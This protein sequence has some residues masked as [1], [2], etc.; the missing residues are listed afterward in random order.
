MLSI[1]FTAI[2]TACVVGAAVWARGADTPG[3]L[4]KSHPR[5]LG[6]RQ[7]LQRLAKQRP[8]AYRR[9]VNVA[10]KHKADD[11][12]KL[13][14][15][16]LVCAIEGDKDLGR[17]A[18]AKVM[19]AISGP[20]PK[21]HRPF[22]STL[23]RCAIVYDLC[24]ESW[25]PPQRTAFHT[26]M[27]RVVDANVRSETHVFHNGWYG[28]KNWGIGLA[29]YATYYENPR[30]ATIL[31][32]VKTDFRTRAAPALELA[33]DGGGWGEGYYIH[34]WLYEW[35]FFCEVA[36]LCD[37]TDYYAMAPG[38]FR[39]RA[40]A[41]MFEMYPGTGIYG[42]RRP[43]PM[44]DGGG[45]VFGGDRDKALSARRILAGRYRDDAAH[46]VV[47]AFNET[48][49]RS[50]VGVY[51]Y[52]DLLWRDAT[53]NRGDLASF[54]LSHFSGGPGYI[55]ARSSWDDT[56][57]H[58]FFKCGDRF[59]AH[60]HL[61]VGNFL[62]YR[63]G[64]LVG[65][66]GHYDGFGTPHDVN[67]HLRT[68]A[69]NT[70]RV[71]DPAETW[72]GIR[73]G[74]VTGNDGGQ[75]HNWAHHN[76]AVTD[77][78]AWKKG[79]KLYDIADMLAFEDRGKWLYAAGDCSRAYSPKKLDYFTRQ[80][81][82]I[83]PGTFVI[84]DR[85]AVRNARFKK[86]WTLQTAK[87]PEGKSGKWTVT[88]GKG[89]LF[90][91]TLLPAKTMVKLISG[92]ELYSYGGKTYPPKRNTG[93]A[94]ECRM[95]VS[96]AKSAKVDHFL[97]VLTATDASTDAAPEA[98]VT[99]ADT[100][101][102][103]TVGKTA[104]AFTKPAVGGSITFNGARRTFPTKITPAAKAPMEIP[105][106]V[107]KYFP[108]KGD[109]IDVGVTGDW[110]ASLKDTRAK[111]DKL[112]ARVSKALQDG[113][114]Y[115][116][117]KNPR[118][119]PS[120]VYRIVKTIE[121]LEPLPTVARR[122]RKV[123]NTDYIAIMKKIGIRKW[124]EDKGVKQ[125]WIWGYHG[126]VV[127]LWESNMAGPFGDISNSNRDP[128]DLPVLRNTYTVYH[129]NYQRGASEAVE[130]HMHQFEAVLNHVD[131]RRRT[132]PDKWDTLLFWGK[133]VGSDR[134]GKIVRPGC[135]W[136]HY[137]PNAEG[138]YD[139]ANKRFVETDIED[140]RPDGKGTRKRMN[141]DRWEGNSLKWFVYWMQNLPGADSGLTY[142]GKKLTNW[143]VFIGDF[144]AAMGRG[145]KLVEK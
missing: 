31:A 63:N 78:A 39:N 16:A 57:T 42:S 117:Y 23:A 75:H 104:I 19:K 120:L 129:Y 122:G 6:S 137:P 58:F 94:P 109:L 93:P 87:R 73:A 115:H 108:V 24:Y 121:Y 46:H 124:V 131:G 61:D 64:E 139:W 62:I 27:N 66:G 72:P 95:E 22:G 135:G 112:A 125:V 12:A 26:F 50:S 40:V 81:V 107:V 44:G 34:Y 110:G 53:I 90:I 128:K 54:K 136:S 55:Y 35:L 43:I 103:V 88:N 52:K 82:Y 123:P 97:H 18:V 99:T 28:Y 38:F 113:S 86:T 106:L 141:C 36:R 1:R 127:N 130:D 111:T 79:R 102:Q 89:R 100:Q 49:P 84:F 80:I 29:C 41:G 67:Y 45:R 10:R 119:K 11:H 142:R 5:L 126:G 3:P 48:T 8:G 7:H 15:M 116:G 132:P 51:A 133:F 14:S 101:V 114:R 17:Q 74:R 37:G 4:P 59:T 20:I 143:W 60:Q 9:V 76:G 2:V 118:A 96:P 69:H 85:V 92:D 13:I 134:T 105:V 25:T 77:P 144:D 30:A 56:A 70:I 138:D 140:W 145:L 71:H 83:R 65:D 98:R 33:G 91:Q 32:G 47:H 21:G 68:I